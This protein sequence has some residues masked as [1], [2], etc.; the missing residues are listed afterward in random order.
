MA[1]SRE[2]IDPAKYDFQGRQISQLARATGEDPTLGGLIGQTFNSCCAP[3]AQLNTCIPTV[4]G[5]PDIKPE[6]Q[7]HVSSSDSDR[8][9]PPTKSCIKTGLSIVKGLFSGA[10]R[11]KTKR[12]GKQP[13][14]KPVKIKQ[15]YKCKPGLTEPQARSIIREL[16][17]IYMN[18]YPGLD[19]Y[20]CNVAVHNSA[21]AFLAGK[22][23]SRGWVALLQEVLSYRMECMHLAT[24]L[25]DKLGLDFPDCHNFDVDAWQVAISD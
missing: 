9:S 4:C 2:K 11:Q 7:N 8:Q 1:S 22:E 24:Q 16:A 19:N 20:G 15:Y 3:D 13:N 17:E 23:T 5:T 10:R 21:N 18:S 25:K 12:K 14:D 6:S